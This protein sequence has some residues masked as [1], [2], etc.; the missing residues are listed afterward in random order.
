MGILDI[1]TGRNE[2]DSSLYVELDKAEEAI[3]TLH[4]IANKIPSL[5]SDVEAAY[6]TLSNAKGMG[7]I[8]PIGLPFQNPSPLFDSASSNINEIASKLETT[9]ND[10]IYYNSSTS[11]KILSTAAMNGV[12]VADQTLSSMEKIG[13]ATT[14]VLGWGISK[15]V[16]VFSKE[17]G[18]AL[19][20]TVDNI[21]DKNL[22]HDGLLGKIYDSD[23]AKKSTFSENAALAG[24]SLVTGNF[25][26]K[27]IN[28]INT[29]A[30]AAGVLAI[31]SKLVSELNKSQLELESMRELSVTPKGGIG[32]QPSKEG[33]QPQ[34]DID[35]TRT[36]DSGIP[37]DVDSSK[38]AEET[39]KAQEELEKEP[40]KQKEKEPEKQKEKE[41]EKQK[42][43]ESEKQK[44]E[45]TE[46]H[47]EEDTEKENTK[48]E[49]TYNPTYNPTPAASGAG[50]QPASS[51]SATPTNNNVIEKKSKDDEKATVEELNKEENN[52]NNNNEKEAITPISI[53]NNTPTKTQST[54]TTNNSVA[55]ETP[56]VTEKSVIEPKTSTNTKQEVNY[57]EPAKINRIN[58]IGTEYLEN[59]KTVEQVSEQDQPTK[60]ENLLETASTSIEGTMYKPITKK[61]PTS[62]PIMKEDHKTKGSLVVPI[63]AGLSTAA[64]AGLGAKAY[65]DKKTGITDEEE[66]VKTEDENI[67]IEDENAKKDLDSPTAR[68]MREIDKDDLIEIL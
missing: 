17:K 51:G 24:A 33:T 7:L 22:V 2:K 68:F 46:K 25:S 39:Q 54:V 1:I 18:E 47:K 45:D 34:T 6:N 56:V 67:L 62:K 32:M 8:A 21:V 10:Y 59:K 38:D 52:S 49:D 36:I 65:L 13:D 64:A 66:F 57:Y 58:N 5:G 16:E 28:A 14:S 41:P 31:G 30:A 23:F 55:K 20:K 9:K 19:R 4:Q 37:G 15:V 11:E 35:A 26:N 40:E 61:I 53:P 12:H 27:I 3:T 63:G 42:E 44:E 43:E 60:L 29:G 48:L 50:E